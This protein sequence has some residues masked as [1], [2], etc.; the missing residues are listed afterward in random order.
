MK[1]IFE[2]VVYD[3]EMLNKIFSL[4]PKESEFVFLLGDDNKDAELIAKNLLIGLDKFRQ[5]TQLKGR[6]LLH[7]K[8]VKFYEPLPKNYVGDIMDLNSVDTLKGELETNL[9][10]L[11]YLSR[12]LSDE[13]IL[14][15]LY[16][17]FREKKKELS[18][19]SFKKLGKDLYIDEDLDRIWNFFNEIYN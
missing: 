10:F 16:L 18:F 1:D 13:D 11:E 8:G 15:L 2:S 12:F 14:H 4:I 6:Y 3:S 19:E 9:D 7:I 17:H 5:D